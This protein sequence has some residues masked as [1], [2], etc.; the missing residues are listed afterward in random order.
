MVLLALSVSAFVAGNI[1]LTERKGNEARALLQTRVVAQA[2]TG[3]PLPT[4]PATW[5]PTEAPSALLTETPAATATLAFTRTATLMPTVMA[6]PMVTLQA[7][8]FSLMNAQT[9]KFV[10]LSQFAGRPVL[11]FFWATWCHYCE[12]EMSDMEALYRKYK[13]QGFVL[14]AINDGDSRAAINSFRS[15]RGLSFPM[16]VD[17][18]QAVSTL[19]G[20]NGIPQHFF[21]GTNGRISSIGIGTI[22][23]DELDWQVQLLLRYPAPTATP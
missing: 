13:D 22:D 18:N 5:T 6:G 12:G 10:S 21:I 7:P 8:E 23:A 19:Y 14:L 15:S 20:V 3:M 9:G 11:L 1:W 2:L 16:L 4:L 17:A